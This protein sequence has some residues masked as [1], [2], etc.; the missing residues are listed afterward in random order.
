[1][2][3]LQNERQFSI[4][5]GI[6]F[7]GQQM[8]RTRV[9]GVPQEPVHT[10]QACQSKIKQFVMLSQ[11]SMAEVLGIIDI[12][13]SKTNDHIITEINSIPISINSTF[14]TVFQ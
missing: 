12:K 14:S 11:F 7:V 6:K 8:Y 2:D 4:V 3:I 10:D 5:K 13:E 9:W 1:M